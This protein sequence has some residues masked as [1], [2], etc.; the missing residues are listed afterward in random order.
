MPALRP[1]MRVLC[2]KCECWEHKWEHRWQIRKGKDGVSEGRATWS[3]HFGNSFIM[4]GASGMSPKQPAQGS[5]SKSESVSGAAQRKA[6]A[7]PGV[8]EAEG[9]SEQAREAAVVGSEAEKHCAFPFPQTSAPKKEKKKRRKKHGRAHGGLNESIAAMLGSASCK[10]GGTASFDGIYG[11][12]M[13]ALSARMAVLQQ[14]R[15]TASIN[16]GRAPEAMAAWV[17]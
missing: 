16:G 12:F 11:R 7:E 17:S 10:H 9:T 8:T 15:S 5:L 4:A 2:R 3:L 13:G 6:G 14:N 1:K